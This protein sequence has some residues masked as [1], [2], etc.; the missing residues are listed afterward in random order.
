MVR[1]DGSALTLDRFLV[2]IVDHPARGDK[3]RG[4]DFQRQRQ[5]G[6]LVLPFRCDSKDA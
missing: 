6:R 3:S 2:I 4:M 5:L 1:S